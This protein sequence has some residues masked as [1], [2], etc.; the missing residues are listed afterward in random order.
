MFSVKEIMGMTSFSVAV[1]VVETWCSLCY[2]DKPILKILQL[3]LLIK[4]MRDWRFI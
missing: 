2:K 4:F 1:I 3:C